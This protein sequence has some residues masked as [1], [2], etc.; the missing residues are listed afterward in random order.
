MIYTGLLHMGK[1]QNGMYLTSI[2]LTSEYPTNMYLT[3]V[4]GST[5]RQEHGS[6]M[7]I[8]SMTCTHTMGLGYIMGVNSRVWVD[9]QVGSKNTQ[10]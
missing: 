7:G 10:G 6:P 3:F 1:Y 9:A 8:W 4:K 5:P 2:Y